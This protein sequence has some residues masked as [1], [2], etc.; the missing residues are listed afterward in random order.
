MT[1]RCLLL[2]VALLTGSAHAAGWDLAQLMRT[3]AGNAGGTVR[4]VETRYLAI[5]DQ[6]LTATGEL[7]YIAPARLERH[8]ETPLRE[9]MVLDGDTLTLSREGKTHTL[10]LRDYPEA[11][12]L[13]D[14]IRATLAGD[15][16]ALERTYALSL[17]GTAAQWT[18][19]LLPSDQAVAKVVLRI[20]VSGSQG[21]VRG[22][23]IFQTDGD[24]SVM[25]IE[26]PRR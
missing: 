14:S 10:R 11:A 22:V 25:R 17:A 19:D 16:A 4:F 21:E 15:R 12:A 8:T 9:S 5:L 13:I 24:R 20:R 26:P 23:E 6:P 2:L 7:V 18:L 1:G 3:L